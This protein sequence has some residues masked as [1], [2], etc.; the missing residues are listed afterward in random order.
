MVDSWNRVSGEAIEMDKIPMSK[1]YLDKHVD[2]KDLQQYE[3]N[4]DVGLLLILGYC[5]MYQDTM[6]SFGCYPVKSDCVWVQ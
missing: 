6:K 4:A 1:R 2:L 3:L 5:H